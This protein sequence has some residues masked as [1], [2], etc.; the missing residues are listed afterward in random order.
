M[1]NIINTNQI[2]Y[3]DPSIS[4]TDKGKLGNPAYTVSNN[5]T[6]YRYVSDLIR[7]DNVSISFGYIHPI[8][9]PRKV[10]KATQKAFPGRSERE[11]RVSEM[12]RGLCFILLSVVMGVITS[13]CDSKSNIEDPNLSHFV[14]F[15]GEDGDQTGVDLVLL[16]DGTYILFGTSGATS[17][18]STT[19]WYLVKAD[20]RG[21]VMWEKRFGSQTQNETASDIELTADNRLVAVGNTFKGPNDRDVLI[22][23]FT[24]D[25]VP[26]NKT[27]VALKNLSGA[28]TDEDA[29][30]VSLTNDGFVVAGSTSNTDIKPNAV[31]NDQR[32]AM[33]LRFFN[34]LMQY[35]NT[36]GITTG[37]GTYDAAVKVIQASPTQFYLF[38]YSNT[39][40]NGH[41]KT[42][43][44]YWNFGLGPNAVPNTADH[45]I[46]SLTDDERL[47][48]VALSPVQ[49]GEG[50]FLG[51]SLMDLP[52][53]LIFI[54]RN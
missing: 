54:S 34:N 50:Y 49:S 35:P 36:W 43:L 8:Y 51:G 27:T 13:G 30:S 31:A 45:F 9:N 37:P 52:G 40:V 4:L 26:I 53:C 41:P 10:K 46:G 28:D 15:Y 3:S 6:R 44:N 16:S 12:I 23:T 24:L 47:S 22:M 20:A 21:M 32:D 48:S 19:Q 11:R 39:V 1:S 29:V 18:D 2:Y 17:P 25:G 7:M 42:D 33:H 14:K 38:G 5:I